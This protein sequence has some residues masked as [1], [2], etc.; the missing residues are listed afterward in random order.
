MNFIPKSKKT[1]AKYTLLSDNTNLGIYPNFENAYTKDT[2]CP[3][4]NSGQLVSLV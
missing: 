2:N 4:V 1:I 3:T